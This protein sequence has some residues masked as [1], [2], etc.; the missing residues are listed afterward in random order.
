MFLYEIPR[1]HSF[2]HTNLGRTSLDKWSA[3][4]NIY[5]YIFLS[6][7][8]PIPD[9]GFLVGGFAITLTGRSTLGMTPLYEWS[10]RHSDLYAKTHNTHNRHTSMPRRDSNPQAQQASSRRPTPLTARPPG[11][12]VHRLLVTDIWWP[13]L[14]QHR[15]YQ[16]QNPSCGSKQRLFFEPTVSALFNRLTPND[17]YM[18]RTTA[19]L[20]SKRCILY[21][22]STNIGT[23]Y[24]KHALYSP[25][26]L[27][28][29]QFVL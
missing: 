3:S 19:P 9:H 4:R 23:E 10:A 21:I 11:P 12:A 7:F 2:R 29:M 18:G 16:G 27:F 14:L 15:N 8:D 25:F 5:I 24:F 13:G 20:T 28:K 6:R 17:P 22:Y 26:F 1:T